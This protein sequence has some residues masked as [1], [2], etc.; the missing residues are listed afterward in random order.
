LKRAA[1]GNIPLDPSNASRVRG[2]ERGKD[3]GLTVE[4]LYECPVCHARV[5]LAADDDILVL[6]H[7][8]GG[9]V[10]QVVTVDD[11]EI[12]RCRLQDLDIKL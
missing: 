1:A 3:M 5:P 6:L 9:H 4:R 11:L 7:G 12:H 8:R 10:D 2:E